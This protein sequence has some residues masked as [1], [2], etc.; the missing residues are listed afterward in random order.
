M[1]VGFIGL[2]IMGAPMAEK[3]LAGGHTLYAHTRHEVPA[4]LLQQGA[5]ACRDPQQVADEAEVIFIMVP[6]T[7]QVEEVLFGERGC[8]AGKLN[9][10]VVV[11]MSSISPLETKRFAQRIN[12]LGAQY[13]DAPVS[14][15]EVGAK[16]GTLTIMVG[17]EEATFERVQPL[18]ALM[19][20]TSR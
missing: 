2:G 14:G 16:Q 17:G 11:D 7:P 15:G 12:Q 9:G 6:D 19:G 1:K 8:A 3:L 10:K 18:L 4:A 5:I 13:L 20:R